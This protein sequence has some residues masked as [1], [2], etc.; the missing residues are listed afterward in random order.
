MKILIR[1]IAIL[2]MMFAAHVAAQGLKIGYVNGLRIEKESALPAWE[3]EQMK[4]EFAPR[5][6]RL[7][8]LQKQGLELQSELEKEGLTMSPDDKQAKEKRLAALS[9]QF[10]QLQRS[11]A[12]DLELRKNEARARF[13][14][15]TNAIIRGIAEAGKY[16]LIVQQAIYGS[17]QIDITEQVLKEMAKLAESATSPGK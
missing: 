10:E 11:V 4:K 2:L 6:Q 5:E 14:A 17:P 12:E 13:L 16:D 9:R 1:T 15:E 3:I 8:E 7:Q